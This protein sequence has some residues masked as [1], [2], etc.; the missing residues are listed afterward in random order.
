MEGGHLDPFERKDAIIAEVVEKAQ[1]EAP[2]S[3]HDE[4]VQFVKAFFAQAAPDDVT[5]QPVEQ[6]Y[7]IA[8]YMWRL[9]RQRQPGEP[10]VEVFNPRRRKDGWATPHTAVAIVNDDMPF[11]VDSI[12]GGI[13]V[14]HR[15]RIHV[16]HHP[17]LIVE[18]SEKGR[19]K[20]IAGVADTERDDRRPHGRES[21]MYLEIDAESDQTVLDELCRR[22]VA[23]LDDVRLA[24]KDWRPMLAKIDETVASLTAHQPP[25]S[26]DLQE[27]TVAFLRWL[28]ADRFTFLGYREYQFKGDLADSEFVPLQESGLGILRDPDRHILRGTGGFTAISQEIRHFLTLP[29]RPII[30]TK[31][32][33]KATVH[34]PV[35]MDYVG[36]KIYDD[37]G[38]VVGERR[39]VGLFTS[40]AYAESP[41]ET[42]LLRRKAENVLSRAL[43][44]RRSHAG[45]ALRHI[46]ETFPRDELFQIDEDRLLQTGLGILHLLERPRPR[47]FIR[48]DQFERFVSALVYVPR[49]VYHSGLREAVANILCTA[50]NGELSVYYAQLSEDVLARWHFIIRTQPGNVPNADET[51][52][53]RQIAEA[54]KGWPERLR[55]QLVEAHGEER[56]LRLYNRYGQVFSLAYQEDFEPRQ[57]LR[58]I[59][60][61]EELT[62]P[63]AVGFEFYRRRTD[64][65][66][67]LR[68]KMYHASQIVP[69]SQCLPMLE[70]LGL[71]VISENAYELERGSGG[72]IH[73]FHLVKAGGGSIENLSFKPLMEELLTQVWT[74]RVEND[75]FNALVLDAGLTWNQIVVLRACSR[76][77]R[78]L[79]LPFGQAYVAACLTE[80]P[81]ISKTLL[82]LFETKFDPDRKG[83]ARSRE[84]AVAALEAD[85]A[86]QLDVVASLDQDRILR[87]YLSLVSATVRTNYFQAFDEPDGDD[88]DGTACGLAL[89]VRSQDV[90]EAPLPRPWREIFVYSPRVEG[91]HLRWGHVARGGLRWSD[92]RQDFRTEVLGLV[93]A[94]QVKNAVIVPVGAKGGF[95]PKRLPPPAKREA[96]FAEGRDCYKSFVASLLSITDNLVGGKIV[97]PARVVRHDGDDAYL[98]VAA[99]K[100]TATFSDLANKIALS[101]GFWLGDAFASGGSHGYDH[102]AMGITARGAWVS[103]E[104]HFR[105]MGI[106]VARDPVRVIGIGDMSGDVFGNGMLL[107]E[108]L[109]LVAAFDHRHVF[110]DPDPDPTG[111]LQERRR[112]FALDRSGWD[113]YDRSLI[114]KGGGVWPRSAKSISLSPEMQ[115]L[116][117]TDRKT[118]TPAELIH[119]LLKVETDLLWFG[120]I[121]TYVKASEESHVDVGDRANDA[122]RVNADELGAK[123]V[124]EGANLALTQRARIQFA[125]LGGRVNTDFIDNSAGVACSDTEVNI[126]I[127][128]ADA[129]AT[130]RLSRTKRDEL[131]AAMTEEVARLVLSENYLQTEALTLAEAQS[132]AARESHAGLIRTLEREGSLNRELEFLPSEEQFSELTLAQKG[133]TRPELA[134]VMAHAKLS[135]KAILLNGTV[136]DEPA[137]EVELYARFPERLRKQF[138]EEI[139]NHRLRRE[140]IATALV[141]QI[142]NRGGLTFV[143]DVREATGL[144]VD[145]ILAAY[146][147]SRDVFGL[148]EIRTAIDDLDY[149]VPA[150]IQTL[151]HLELSE[152][153]RQQTIWFLRNEDRPFDIEAL[154]NRY[155]KGVTTLMARSESVLSPIANANFESKLGMYREHNV[156][157]SLARRVATLLALDFACDVEKVA[158]GLERPADDVARAYSTVGDRLGFD[159]L[160]QTS[161]TISLEDHWDRLAAR[162][163]LDDLADQ[164]RELAHH[165]LS[166]MT[167]G[168]GQL[169]V[170]DWLKNQEL[171]RLRAERLLAE[172]RSS[173]AMSVA[174]LSF[175][176]R[177]MRSIL[178]RAMGA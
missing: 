171:T 128:L 10:K 127:A 121:G 5:A 30:T 27:E 131:L 172:L 105:E 153:T 161:E 12:T 19:R 154:V 18:R 138:A 177:H 175:A 38:G 65:G 87:N 37:D 41:F 129:M 86:N 125:R 148:N 28:G 45:K 22:I 49:D 117:A 73:D 81:E 164:Q 176:A 139:K 89:K 54:V 167:S 90:E 122:V 70:N 144:G 97:P 63:G 11:L 25:V 143:Y 118:L 165:I 83:G 64:D 80:N 120:G 74:R 116:L 14:T 168:D 15:H 69:L 95:V 84:K 32:N 159:W 147:V 1:K 52:I 46:V 35:H 51:E 4:I 103:V 76:F 99:D 33:V 58:D 126:K 158:I 42:P 151:M 123:V 111:S 157:E 174:K 16:V 43:F 145:Q 156:P 91:V 24:V 47:A 3:N 44:D 160:R 26:A 134:V 78:Q 110:V 115:K 57:A 59:A 72:C 94:Q 142:V 162:A 112:L 137:P 169:C 101:H 39:F 133:L 132:N 82:Q 29:E 21:H 60:K 68:L 136:I 141:N 85:I 36:V 6:L 61:L 7:A 88:D 17:I 170:E 98:V 149:R 113:D 40:Q 20:R 155:G 119:G 135:L 102:K 166:V 75:G 34:R 56:G 79:G 9:G 93:K 96:Y 48:R 55:E 13:A 130:K 152:F 106:D 31:A 178:A 114:S 71:K 67:I 62:G 92:R 146:L 104:R 107:S 163:Q 140:L 77:L 66:G 100:G 108:S 173:G 53:D 124:A 109:R 50:F 2:K 8:L 150:T 23:I